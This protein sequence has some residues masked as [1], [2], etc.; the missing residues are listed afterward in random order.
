MG[1]NTNSHKAKITV[2]CTQDERAYIKMLAA[3]SHT[4]ISEF[5]LSHL[6]DEF[7]TEKKPNAETVAAMNE[8]RSGKTIKCDSMKDFW[9]KMG[10]KPSA[11]N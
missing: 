1:A 10:V 3:N 9:D 4:T 8:S 6:R 7:P 11:Y 2:D 5:I